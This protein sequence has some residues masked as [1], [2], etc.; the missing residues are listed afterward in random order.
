MVAG[1]DERDLNFT[2]TGSSDL[3]PPT[4]THIKREKL[5]R[6]AKYIYYFIAARLLPTVV[7][8]EVLK[9]R[10]ILTYAILKGMLVDVGQIIYLEMRTGREA[11]AQCT[12]FGFPA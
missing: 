5:T 9:H 6:N 8:S 1:V 12:S 4:W 7:N 2:L 10:V 11:R 3:L